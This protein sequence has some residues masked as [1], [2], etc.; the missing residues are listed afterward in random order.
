MV[1]ETKAGSA[2]SHGV[3]PPPPLALVP[4]LEFCVQNSPRSRGQ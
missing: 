4:R 2:P 1:R 3:G